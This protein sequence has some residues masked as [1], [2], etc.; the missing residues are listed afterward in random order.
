MLFAALPL[1]TFRD[2][3]SQA[4]VR[5]SWKALLGE[6]GAGRKVNEVGEEH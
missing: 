2:L 6:Q 1:H 4:E 5:R 3:Q